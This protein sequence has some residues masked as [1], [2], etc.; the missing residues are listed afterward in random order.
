MAINSRRGWIGAAG[1]TGLA[2]LGAFVYRAAPAFWQQY[3][4]DSKRRIA[5]APARPRIQD[6]PSRGVFAAWLGH[7]TVLL[8]IDGFTVLTDPVFSERAGLNLGITTLGIK[9]LVQPPL[10]ISELPPIDLILVSHAHMDHLDIPS[11]RKL[12]NSRTEVVTAHATG[13]LFRAASYRRLTELKWGEKGSAGPLSIRAIEVNHWGAR[14]RTDTYRGYNGYV[15]ESGNRRILFGG[16]TAMTSAFRQVRSFGSID[17]AIM[18]IGAYNPWI[19][20]HCTPE[21]ALNMAN[22]ARA[23]L[24]LPVHHRTFQLGREP[25][26]EPMDRL[27]SAAGPRPER[28]VLGEIGQETRL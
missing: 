5:T 19:H 17:L 2:G 7:S 23:E 11:L 22:D 21:Q 1:L 20:Y 6:W 25:L 24:V 13:D 3:Y 15:I 27:L 18:P 16:D 26:S 10:Q 28:I 12:E 14:M 8:K 4:Q 9:R